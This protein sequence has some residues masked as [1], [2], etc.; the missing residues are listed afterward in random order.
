VTARRRSFGSGYPS[1]SS[2]WAKWARKHPERASL[3]ASAGW[4]WAR[5]QQLAREPNCW[6]GEK[7]SAVDHRVP[8]SQCGE[9]LDPDNLQS[10]CKQHHG[11]KT[12]RESHEGMKRAAE[13][14]KK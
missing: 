4:K 8:L 2:G 11:N 1:G 9:L 3:Y 7:A 12:L 14:R 13:R 6:C 10:L 5:S